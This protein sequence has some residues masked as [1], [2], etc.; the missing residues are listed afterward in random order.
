[1]AKRTALVAALALACGA[2]GVHAQDYPARPI[3]LVVPYSAGGGNDVMARIVAEKMSRSLGQQ[4]VIENKGGAGG[5]IATR[6][7]AKSPPDRY[8]L[9]LGGPGTPAVNS[10]RY[11]QVACHPRQEFQSCVPVG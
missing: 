3:T 6:Q 4:I 1:M 5:S 2:A 8:T 11:T 7:G 9:G 10:T